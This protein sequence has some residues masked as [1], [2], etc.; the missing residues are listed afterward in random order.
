MSRYMN[1]WM[2]RA[3]WRFVLCLLCVGTL[4][5]S[6]LLAQ[7]VIPVVG[8]KDERLPEM[9]ETRLAGAGGDTITYHLSLPGK[10]RLYAPNSI[11]DDQ[12]ALDPVWKRLQQI[13][14][15][16]YEAAD[17]LR[18]LHV[19][20]SHIRGHIYPRVTGN[21]FTS[22]FAAC[23]YTDFGINGATCHTFTQEDRLC[24]IEAAHA[25]LIILS[26]GTN[27]SHNRRYDARV[28]YRQMDELLACLRSRMPDVPI[29]LTTPPGSYDR[30]WVR[31]RKQYRVNPRTEKAAETIVHFAADHGL[32]VWNM[33]E[34]VGGLEHACANWQASHLM[35][36]D[37]IHYL[38]Q[39]YTLQGSLFYQAI[40]NA[41]NAYVTR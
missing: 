36:P 40:V 3:G 1:N 2:N 10:F 24:K 4:P 18:V 33:Y 6:S 41:Y 32:A 23:T 11:I 8:L 17:T 5:V 38:A 16:P 31:K 19:G 22:E 28:H 14:G 9:T 26:F 21:L 30:Y 25:D 34:V 13:K 35:R 15:N 12:G 27:E 29:L 39:G 7:D 20:D 37:H